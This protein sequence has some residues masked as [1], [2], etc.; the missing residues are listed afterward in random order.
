MTRTENLVLGQ[1]K[2]LGLRDARKRDLGTTA[3]PA[4]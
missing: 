4:C 1:L 2:L 3:A